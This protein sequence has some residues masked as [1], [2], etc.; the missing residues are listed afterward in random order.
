MM[1]RGDPHLAIWPAD[2]TRLAGHLRRLETAQLTA[3]V[4]GD[5]AAATE[6]RLRI[7]RATRELQ[8]ACAETMAAEGLTGDSGRGERS[9]P[10]S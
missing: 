7:S 6:L 10:R 5:I 1:R 2:V 9:G 8:A 4:T 3:R